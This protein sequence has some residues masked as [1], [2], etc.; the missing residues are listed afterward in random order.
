MRKI[1]WE[2]N[3][4]HYSIV[5]LRYNTESLMSFNI[6][7]WEKS[8]ELD[9]FFLLFDMLNV[10]IFIGFNHCSISWWNTL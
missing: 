7:S 6:F 3:S 5:I 9:S 8:F 1:A 4:A 2:K 10:R